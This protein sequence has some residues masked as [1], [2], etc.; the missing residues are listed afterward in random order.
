M[1]GDGL[2]VCQGR[3]GLGIRK[4]FFSESGDAEVQL[5]REV[6]WSPSLE[7]FRRCGTEG[8]GGWARWGRAGIWA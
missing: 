6:V 1:R 5:L 7:V 3:F 2:K 4:H 8:C